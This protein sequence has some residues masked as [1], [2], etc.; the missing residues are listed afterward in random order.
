[1]QQFS[2]KTDFQIA[3]ICYADELAPFHIFIDSAWSRAALEF[4]SF[5]SR[6]HVLNAVT[7]VPDCITPDELVHILTKRQAVCHLDQALCEDVWNQ[8]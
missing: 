1:M 3:P 7:G 2:H 6:H 8:R 5:D 4:D